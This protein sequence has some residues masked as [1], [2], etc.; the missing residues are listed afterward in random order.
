MTLTKS[1]HRMLAGANPN[2]TDTT[3]DRDGLVDC[4]AALQALLD[5]A[6]TRGGQVDIGDARLLI[7]SNL[8]VPAG[9][10]LCGHWRTPGDLTKDAGTYGGTAPTFGTM[11]SCLILGAGV[12]IT[13][14]AGGALAG[15]LV[16]RSGVN[17]PVVGDGT[18]SGTAVTVDGDDCYIGYCMFLGHTLAINSDLSGRHKFEWIFGDCSG[19]IKIASSFDVSRITNCH[20]WPWLSTGND[21]VAVPDAN[22]YRSGVGFDIHGLDIG[23]VSDCFAFGYYRGF[24]VISVGAATFTNC[25]T[26]GALLFA[27][28]IGFDIGDGSLGDTGTRFIGCVV[29]SA[30]NGFWINLPTNDYVSLTNCQCSAVSG[31]GIYVASGDVGIHGGFLAATTANVY[32]ANALSKVSIVGTRFNSASAPITGLSRFVEV[33]GIDTGLYVGG[34]AIGSPGPRQIASA[35][36]L[37]ITA[38]GSFFEV[39]GVTGFSTITAGYPGRLIILKF[40]GILTVTDGVPIKLNGDFITAANSTLTLVS[41]GTNWFEVARCS[42]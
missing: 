26:D 36:P 1:H 21:G 14:G 7:S 16:M 27:G 11:G 6:A 39:L 4:T 15:L 12:S 18:Y 37:V 42:P 2:I 29:F 32:V 19:G 5:G 38:T 28:S 33:A 34:A 31:T 41:D 13:L 3:A 17:H 22:H 24:R 9:V 8:A 35:S 20:F 10:T 23:I 30:V 40:A 25:A